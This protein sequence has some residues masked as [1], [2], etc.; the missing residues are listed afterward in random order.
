MVWF[1][2]SGAGAAPP[3]DAYARFT[4]DPPTPFTDA[5]GRVLGGS[6]CVLVP[7]YH[8]DAGDALDC[9]GIPTQSY[10]KH[11]G[12]SI[13]VFDDITVTAW[14]RPDAA[15]V[16]PGAT[17]TLVGQ[18]NTG[19][20]ANPP[21]GFLLMVQDQ[22]L[23]FEVQFADDEERTVVAPSTLSADT[24]AWVVARYQPGWVDLFVDGQWVHGAATL[25]DEDFGTG[26]HIAYMPARSYDFDGGIDEVTLFHSAL[27][28]GQIAELWAWYG[29]DDGDGHVMDGA[30]EPTTEP[31]PTAD[32][33]RPTE[34]RPTGQTGSTAAPTGATGAVDTA[35]PTTVPSSTAD[36]GP[37]VGA[38][39][40]APPAVAAAAGCG[41]RASSPGAA[42]LMALPLL[43]LLRRRRY[44][45]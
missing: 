8:P 34:P 35:P 31:R 5:A 13:D 41:C 45:R 24:W 2:L 26:I 25:T 23:A 37:N 17:C 16:A 22:R 38:P 18:G 36:T 20:V 27:T 30:G 12:P 44:L 32:T 33:G 10:D 4:F 40:G 29:D 43:G 14:V 39:S 1:L 11:A 21:Y 3:V 6:G 9:P 28:D 15:C 7:S 19:D 42:G